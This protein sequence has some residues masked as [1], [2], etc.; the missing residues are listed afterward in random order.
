MKLIDLNGSWRVRAVSK[1]KWV[2]AS[3]PGSIHTDLMAAGL[4]PDP[5]LRDH[6]ADLQ[7]IGRESWVYEREFDTPRCSP[8]ADVVLRC[9]GL[10][11]LATVMV[12]GEV[13]GHADNMH[14]GWRFD[15]RG[16]LREDVN[17]LTIRFDSPL[18]YLAQRQAAHALS[19]GPGVGE[20]AGRGW[21]RKMACQFGWDWAPSLVTC[22]IWRG[23]GIEV[24]EDA[25]IQSVEVRQIH[26]ADGSVALDVAACAARA[27]GAP[28]GL[29]LGARLMYK[30]TFVTE[31]RTLLPDDGRARF[32]LKVRNAQRWWPNGLG[33]QPLYELAVD[34]TGPAGRK[35]IDT[36]VRR[37]GLRTLRLDRTPDGQGGER[38]Q[39]VVN[40]LPFFA[41][42]ATW[43]P[44]DALVTR[45]TRVEY[46]RLAKA[47]SVG[48]MN[49]LRVWGGGIYE[50][51]WFY[52]LCDEYG[53]CVWQDFMFA[54]P[55]YPV[56]DAAWL[57]NVRAEAEHNI[58][59]LRHHACLAL[60]CGNNGIGPGPAGEAPADCQMSC[61]GDARLFD[62]LLPALTAALDPDR[63][64]WPGRSRGSLPGA[65]ADAGDPRSGEA[66]L[67][68]VWG[69]G[70][71]VVACRPGPHRFCSAS[72]LPSFPEP[73][74]VKAFTQ[75]AAC[76]LAS[77]LLRHHQRCAQG[78][79]RIRECIAATFP[80]AADPEDSIWLSQIQQGYALKVAVE[81]WRRARPHVMG[82]LY[83]QL[84]DC[85]PAVSGSSLDYEGNWKAL[86]YFARKFF[87]PI[88][89]SAVADPATGVLEVFVHNDLRQTFKGTVQWRVGD[90]QGRLM[91]ETGCALTIAPGS[92]RRLGVIKLGDLLEKLTPQRLVVWLSIVADDGYVLSSNCTIF[93]PPKEMQI[94]DPGIQ[95][96]IRPWDDHCY[97]VTLTAERPAFWSWIELRDCHAKYDDN[98][99][100]L[101]PHLPMRIRVTPMRNMRI[102][103]FREALR[104]RSM[105][106]LQAGRAPG[107]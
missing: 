80:V 103:E 14:R 46:A 97:A 104:V 94:V 34:L 5:F 4:I 78:D 84:N 90:T 35:P 2:A 36:W 53:I 1:K 83:W 20:P 89:V 32:H 12:N 107:Q 82:A 3:V 87:A 69:G 56:F 58:V 72:G 28:A 86:H 73:R 19:D 64:Y 67:E 93:A 17:T 6:E 21:I 60:W 65:R 30:G 48:N 68:S 74:V 79:E 77:P 39:F 41:K 16:R 99:V 66:H 29:A 13:V 50:Q 101:S 55:A 102:D 100:H 9:D 92:V 7:W 45:P 49:M 47:V 54:C 98:F 88:L 81:H 62:D 25:R 63:D 8:E 18:D 57:E 31:A 24:C 85:W 11:T 75:E 95:V 76:D 61:G 96:E 37:I 40:G 23:I 26:G 105:W 70:A 22:G 42:G 71:P 106:N 52:D 38:F 27:P 33:E 91:R 15:L 59:R 51:D 10:D 43:V 44:P